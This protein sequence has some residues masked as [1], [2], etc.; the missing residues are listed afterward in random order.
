MSENMEIEKKYITGGN[1]LDKTI[2]QRYEGYLVKQL[3]NF[4]NDP[5]VLTLHMQIIS[6]AHTLEEFHKL[7]DEWGIPR[8]NLNIK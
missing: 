2:A 6:N 1:T 7:A 8:L 5:E 4:L 3:S